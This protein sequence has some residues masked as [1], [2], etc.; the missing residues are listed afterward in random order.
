MRWFNEERQPSHG[1]LGS[2]YGDPLTRQQALRLVEW[3]T[4][5]RQQQLLRGTSCR[6]C[7]LAELVARY[8]LDSELQTGRYHHLREVLKNSPHG[9][10]MLELIY[11]QLLMS[12]RITGAW[13]HLE[14]GFELA[15]MLF[16]QHD[17]FSVLKRH[18][19]LRPLPLGKRPLPAEPL[20]QLLTS[21]RVIAQLQ[22]DE[23]VRRVHRRDHTD[24]AD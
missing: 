3:V 4:A 9:R 2:W 22:N 11:G 15:R 24:T 21:A 1:V 18:Q 12:R 19:Q 6:L 23:P 7:S 10:A 14:D 5:R 8:W 20:Q 13:R 16:S 17:Y